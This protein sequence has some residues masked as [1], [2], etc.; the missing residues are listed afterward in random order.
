M[1]GFHC[2]YL[3]RAPNPDMIL[4]KEIGFGMRQGV[5]ELGRLFQGHYV[6]PARSEY[7]IK[8]ECVTGEPVIEP[9]E[10]E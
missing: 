9:L 10:V 5:M 4:V 7:A 2:P 3:A 1:S 6:P 8:E